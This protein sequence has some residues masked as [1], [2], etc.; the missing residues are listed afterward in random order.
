MKALSV[1][2]SPIVEI[3][4]ESDLNLHYNAVIL[5]AT[6]EQIGEAAA[7]LE[8]F[9]EPKSCEGCKYEGQGR[10]RAPCEYCA[11]TLDDEYIP[12]EI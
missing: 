11:R 12:K 2:K 6:R 1:L 4:S 5:F 7:E 8:E 10:Y 9:M 3:G